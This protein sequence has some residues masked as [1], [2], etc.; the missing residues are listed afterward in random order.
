[1]KLQRVAV[2][3]RLVTGRVGGHC[4]AAT[5]APL[6][7]RHTLTAIAIVAAL[8]AACDSSGR[9]ANATSPMTPTPQPAAVIYTMSG[10]VRSNTGVAIADA[11][12]VMADQTNRVGFSTTTGSDGSFSG[13]LP[14]GNDYHIG[15]AKP[16][17]LRLFRFPVAVA[18]DLVFELTLDPGV[19]IGGV[20][21]EIGVGPLGGA[22][23]EI[24]SGPDQGRSTSTAGPLGQ[25]GAFGLTALPGTFTLRATKSGY[26]PVEKSVTAMAD[27]DVDFALKWAYGSC[28]QSVSPVLFDGYT[29]KGGTVTVA[30]TANPGRL[31]TST[32]DTDWIEILSPRSQ[33]G[34]GAVVFRVAEHPIGAATRRGGAVAI[35]CSAMEGQNVWISQLP[36]CQVRLTPIDVR[37]P[38]PPQ[39]GDGK[40]RVHTDVAGCRWESTSD[41]DWV[42]AVGISN[43]NGDFD[44]NFLVAS[45]TTGAP[46][47]AHF[48][49]NE[50]TLDVRQRN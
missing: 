39:G 8:F 12:V 37:D 40:I 15:A 34:P 17:F 21:T 33:V 9:P 45:N 14:A 7:P 48:I 25:Q 10:T 6:S 49:V 38:F 4:A 1:V 43:W 46:R 22:T 30:V 3:L 35:R 26:D 20:V 44:A 2:F 41:A 29:A 36:D 23:V 27:T 31:W 47:S 50:T 18:T 13:R 19:Q 24:T 42:R 5:T 16:G 32:A 28:L 11:S